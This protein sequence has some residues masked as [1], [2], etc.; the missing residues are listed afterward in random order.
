[1]ERDKTHSS[2]EGERLPTGLMVAL[3]QNMHVLEDY[4]A[5]DDTG[6]ARLIERAS[7]T[8][9]AKEMQALVRDLAQFLK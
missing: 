8:H 9:S 6:R 5:L 4:A 2:E 3:A 1:M 7:N